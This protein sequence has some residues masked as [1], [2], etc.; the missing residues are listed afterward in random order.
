DRRLGP[1]SPGRR[2]PRPRCDPARL[3]A[4]RK[5]DRLLRRRGDYH[6]RLRWQLR[7][8]DRP[9]EQRREPGLEPAAA[10]TLMPTVVLLGTLD[11]KGNEYASLRD[12]IREQ[13]VDP[14][15]VDT[16]VFEPQ[17]EPD[18][19]RQ[20][21]AAAAGADVAALAEADNRGAAVET[22]ARGAAAI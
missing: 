6:G 4:R 12:R 19:S 20:E 7:R 2:S 3:V 21:V 22:M 15:L 8:A 14:L 18:V 1:R 17:V 9:Q 13:G 5:A 11:T 10:G 16:G